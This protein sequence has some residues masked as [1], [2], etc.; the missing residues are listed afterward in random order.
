MATIDPADFG[1]ETDRGASTLQ[2][3]LDLDGYIK[4]MTAERDALKDLLRMELTSNPDP[5][6]DLERGISAVLTERRKPASID[7][8]T[9]ARDDPKAGEWLTEAARAGVL[10]AALTPLRALKGKS[11]WA[12]KLL[13]RE[14]NMGIDQVLRIEK[15]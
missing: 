5:I 13:A 2:R 10:N 11:E 6:V 15:A 3:I 1:V 9:M 7:L 14:M 8:G 12:D 4:E